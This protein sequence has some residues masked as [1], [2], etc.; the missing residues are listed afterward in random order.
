MKRKN[1]YNIDYGSAPTGKDSLTVDEDGTDYSYFSA[2]QFGSSGE[3]LLMLIDSGA[4]NSW[5]MGSDCTSS[6]C[7]DHNTFGSANSNTLKV[8][9]NTFNLSYGTGS[10]SGV[11]V[12]DTVAF[13]AEKINLSFGSASAVSDD[14]NSYPFDGILGL[15]RPKSNEMG[16]P[17]FLQAVADAK[18]L[19]SNIFGV[20]LQREKDKATNGEITFG[21][22][23][24]T[25]Y[26]GAL[27]FTNTVSDELLWEIP[28]DDIV[29]G[30]SPLGLTGRSAVIDTGTSFI[31]LPPDDAQKLHG[32]IPGSR[33][34]GE[35]FN[36]PC[37]TATPIKMVF[38]KIAYSISPEDYVGA[39]VTGGDLC[40][41]NIVGL[42][43][44]GPTQWLLGDVFL[45]NVYSVFD[46][47]LNRIGF[48]TKVAAPAAGP[49]S[50][51][52][53]PSTPISSNT[54]S[55]PSPTVAPG[56]LPDTTPTPNSLGA[57]ALHTPLPSAIS[58]IVSVVTKA[59]ASP[60][61]VLIPVAVVSTANAGSPSASVIL[62]V[63]SANP[64]TGAGVTVSK[65]GT[66]P[67]STSSP[68]GVLGFSSAAASTFGLEKSSLYL[69]ML[70]AF[71][72]IMLCT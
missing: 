27:S 5:I 64:S 41:S 18:L 1:N 66:S 10:V 69:I 71:S 52:S 68:G 39:K 38:N 37:D 32:Q 60:T 42:Q 56:M 21:S 17:T 2:L 3:T 35:I 51:A 55:P 65:S 50:S 19:P 30:S 20:N 46:S 9:Q 70:F 23:D 53:N 25:K 58:T 44:L 16:A 26:T 49:A 72:L 29:V 45:K 22:P 36:I 13:A 67:T 4:S 7:G 31:L 48:G 40:S 14:F 63:L 28:V 54:A 62:Q 59:G 15:G 34:T 11:V 43:A 57:T 8:S 24:T 61:T 6:A 12:S 33:A 47:D